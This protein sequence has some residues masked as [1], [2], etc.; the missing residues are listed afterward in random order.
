MMARTKRVG[1]V[2]NPVM[3]VVTRLALTP[4]RLWVI[5]ATR[6][7]LCALPRGAL[8]AVWPPPLADGR[9]ALHIIDQLRAIALPGWTPVRDRGM[10][11][12]QF[13]LSSIPRPWN[14]I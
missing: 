6:A 3:T 12:H 4:G 13:T 8:D 9:R 1:Q 10:G 2:I 5:N 11:C 14:P 7:D